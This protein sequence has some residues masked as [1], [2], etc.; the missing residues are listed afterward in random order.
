MR[1]NIFLKCF[2]VLA[3][4][5]VCIMLV[6]DIKLDKKCE[7]TA[8]IAQLET[9]EFCP[10]TENDIVMLLGDGCVSIDQPGRGHYSVV[11]CYHFAKDNYWVKV[12]VTVSGLDRTVNTIMVS[13]LPCCAMACCKECEEYNYYNKPPASPSLNAISLGATEKDVFRKYGKP[14]RKEKI[15]LGSVNTEK[16]SFLSGDCIHSFAFIDSKV[17]AIEVYAGE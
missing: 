14:L 5:I 6:A 16:V 4:A 15:T 3:S 11:H 9:I 7:T 13:S 2:L 17:A 1:N 10:L 8:I 12:V